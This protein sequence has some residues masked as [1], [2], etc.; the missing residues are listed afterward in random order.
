MRPWNCL[1][2]SYS[3]RECLGRE[4]NIPFHAEPPRTEQDEFV[5]RRCAAPALWDGRGPG[6]LTLGAC[7][8]LVSGGNSTPTAGNHKSPPQ[9]TSQLRRHKESHNAPG[10]LRSHCTP[11]Q[12]PQAPVPSRRRVYVVLVLP[13]GF[14][15]HW[16]RRADFPLIPL[17]CGCVGEQLRIKNSHHRR[18]LLCLEYAYA[19]TR[20][21]KNFIILL[22]NRG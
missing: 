4:E 17:L 3:N 8:L 2:H 11:T 10:R 19:T 16:A 20:W 9:P 7:T 18:Q 14:L 6:W 22:G 13:M 15:L 5:P 21:M 12:C 1:M